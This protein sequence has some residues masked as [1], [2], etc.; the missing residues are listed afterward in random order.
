MS[1]PAI[2]LF[3]AAVPLDYCDM[4]GAP[5][6]VAELY[7]GKL[8]CSMSCQTDVD[9]RVLRPDPV[10]QTIDDWC[11]RLPKRLRGRRR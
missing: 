10:T 1:V 4:C 11:Q 8:V 9:R 5:V 2:D 6:F 7:K 3:N